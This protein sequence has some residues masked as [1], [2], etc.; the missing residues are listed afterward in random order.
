MVEGLEGVVAASTRL[1]RVE[2]E[3][4]RLTIAGYDVDDL[5][6]QA[7]FEEVAFLLLHGRLPDPP[8]L[9]AF[10][11]A[12]AARRAIPPI[13]HDVLRAAAA[14]G[15]APMDALRMGASLLSLGRTGEAHAD[16]QTAIA[17]FPTIV[18]SYWRYRSGSPA[19]PIR[20]DLP[21]SVPSPP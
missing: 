7:M 14:D 6:P 13:V 5:A 8:A 2:G 4:G 17:A 10:S 12:L 19:V 16:A 20:N 1:S 9:D 15:T 3:A 18:G 11:Q 21:Q